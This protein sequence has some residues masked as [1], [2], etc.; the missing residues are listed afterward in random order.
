VAEARGRGVGAALLRFAV[1]RARA[2]GARAVRLTTNEQN[3]A[4]QRFY[5][6]EGFVPESEAIWP[7]GREILLV[8]RVA[9]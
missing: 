4:A 5:G 3:E 2:R 9:P 1:A 6:R 7:G 8:R